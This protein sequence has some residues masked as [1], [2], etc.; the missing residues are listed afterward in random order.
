M[1]LHNMWQSLRFNLGDVV[2]RLGATPGELD[3]I[4]FR[5][6]L[7]LVFSAAMSMAGIIWGWFVLLFYQSQL[8]AIPPFAYALLSLINVAFF[9]LT[10]RF[11]LFRFL[12]LLLSL[13]LPFLMMVLLGGFVGGSAVILWSLIAPLA[14]LLVTGS[15]QASLWFLAFLGLVL[16]S[17]IIEP[18]APPSSARSPLVQPAFFFMNITGVSAAAFILLRYFVV[19]KDSALRENVR[20]YNEAQEA[21][22]AA[23]A[24]SQAKSAFLAT[25]S[26]EIRTPMNAVIGMTSLLL[27]T[28]LTPEQREF[29]ETIRSS[30]DSLLT[31]IN[32]ILDFSKIEAGRLDLEN[33]PFDL[34]NCL[35]DVLDLMAPKASEKELD[36]A[37]LVD[38]NTPE[39]IV[40]DVTRLRQ[41][42]VNLLSNAIKFTERG[43]VV[44]SVKSHQLS[45]SLY[46]LHISVRDT[47]IGIP[48]ERMDRLFRSFSQVDASTTRRY[49]GTGLGLA[50]S[51]RLSEMM[52]GTMWVESEVGQGSIFHFTIQAQAAPAPVRAYLREIQPQLTGR[53]VLIV[54][55]NPTNR[56]IL[57]LQT[58]SWGMEPRVAVSPH[59][60]LEWIREG[61]A[62]D[63]AIL[64]MQM[65][66]MDGLQLSAKI[67]HFWNGCDLPIVLLTSLGGIEPERRTEAEAIELN[68]LLSKP[69]KPSQLYETLLEIATGQPT[70]IRHRGDSQRSL[71]DPEMGER[72]PL[73]ILLVDDNTTNQKLGVRI[74]ERLGYRADVAANGLEALQALRRQPYDVV[75]MDVQMPEM[76]GME[77]TRR[78]RQEWPGEQGPYIIAMTANAMREDRE[79]CLAIGMDDYISKPVRVEELI[80]ALVKARPIS[81]EETE[82][83]QATGMPATVVVSHDTRTG[84][85]EQESVDPVLDAAALDSLREMVGGEPAYLAELI[86]SFLEDA[87]GLLATMR[88][89]LAQE[90]A[91]AVRLAAHTLKSNGADFGAMR[92]SELNKSVETLAREGTLEGATDLVEQIQAEYEQ[93]KVALQVVRGE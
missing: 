24:A 82:G 54:D 25:M 61:E 37:Y 31:I 26:H 51:R 20:L 21:R 42:L 63:V 36:L 5:K 22:V 16:F 35:E 64:D 62:F 91:A 3:E 92:F 30:G 84:D 60:A 85:E 71:F 38:D 65:P 4:R 12:Q 49:G 40:G 32:D 81:V 2:T 86:D 10:R 17:S 52:G 76:D 29:T 87:P 83:R 55:D 39:A 53:R 73:H 23:E 28:D 47:G 74:L 77:A 41:I 48:P 57:K 78:I 88:D 15:R 68:S 75:L 46:E 69:I 34:R 7:V 66:G 11:R 19:Q 44:L 6:T 9:A 43:E 14:A 59:E 8:A 45:H 70:R 27:D 90:D 56:R 89:G 1:V 33:Q 72:L 93:V 18:F 13:L 80:A 79:Q 58:E 67:R 50:I